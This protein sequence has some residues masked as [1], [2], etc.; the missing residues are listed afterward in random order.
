M[1]DV[2]LCVGW[3]WVKE[4]KGLSVLSLVLRR[5][6]VSRQDAKAQGMYV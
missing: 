2:W 3:L 6:F 1:C 4:A 5:G